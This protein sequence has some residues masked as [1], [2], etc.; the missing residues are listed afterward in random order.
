[1]NNE[2]GNGIVGLAMVTLFAVIGLSLTMALL[3][4]FRYNRALDAAALL[5][6]CAGSA[7]YILKVCF[8]K[9]QK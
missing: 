7:G 1:M 9:N 6:I 3:S 8:D 2:S 4:Y 5:L